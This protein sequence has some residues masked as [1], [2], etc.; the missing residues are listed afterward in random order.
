MAVAGSGG[1][2]G[3]GRGRSAHPFWASRS[4]SAVGAGPAH[5]CRA[6]PD[7]VITWNGVILDVIKSEKTP[8]PLATRNLAMVHAAI[9]DAVNAIAPTHSFYRFQSDAPAAADANVAAAIAA[10]RVLASLY[11]GQLTRFDETLDRCLDAVPESP[12]KSAG[13]TL[14]QSVAEKMLAWRDND[15]ARR[16]VTVTSGRFVGQWQATP[17]D[18]RPALLPQWPRVKCF[19]MR[20]GTQFRPEPP[21]P[22][23]SAAYARSLNQVKA[24]G[25]TLSSARTMDQTE[26][27]FFWADGEGTVTPPGHWNRIARTVARERGLT[28][29]EN[30][31]LFALLNL[32]LADAAILC[33]DC[34]YHYSLWRPVTAIRYADRDGNP[35]TDADPDWTSLLPNPNFPSYT[36]GHSSFSGTAAAVLAHFFG[37]DEVAFSSGSDGLP[38]VTRSYTSFS[39]AANEAGMSR[40]YGG[41][42]YDFDN[43]A[44][45]AS[46]R[47]LGDYV[48]NNFLLPLARASKEPLAPAFAVRRR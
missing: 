41:I 4:S 15:G 10:H 40:I 14:G 9:W 30:A 34:K 19:C 21:P 32:A 47:Q 39:A 12:A 7:A 16:Q 28:L 3:S 38:A 42:H 36:S 8:P 24:L 29:A 31:R 27:A 35:D 18:Y 17:P 45:L 13:I 43:T 25:A 46:G 22:L 48:C 6:K 11:P 44:G 2:G 20:N 1:S 33:W 5:R 26:I 37:T 23:T